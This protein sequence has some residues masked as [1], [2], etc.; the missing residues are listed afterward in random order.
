MK[1]QYLEWSVCRSD[2]KFQHTRS[3]VPEY[4]NKKKSYREGSKGIQ[5]GLSL[6]EPMP[7]RYFFEEK[8]D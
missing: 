3:S 5:Y 6:R 7:V 4:D 2:R 1:G 8:C